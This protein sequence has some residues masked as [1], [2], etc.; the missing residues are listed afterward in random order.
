MH[1]VFNSAFPVFAAGQAQGKLRA[2]LICRYLRV[3]EQGFAALN[4]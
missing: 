2:W 4:C 3:L 1:A